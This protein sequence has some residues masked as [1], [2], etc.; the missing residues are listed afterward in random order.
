M[1]NT[2]HLYD[3]DDSAGPF[4]GLT[5]DFFQ[6]TSIR[7][8]SLVDASI[9]ADTT[10]DGAQSSDMPN[11]SC[12]MAAEAFERDLSPSDPIIHNDATIVSHIDSINL[13]LHCTD[14]LLDAGGG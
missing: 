2:W 13:N 11:E 6:D 1:A 5:E 7:V 12:V 9:E 14:I 10:H 4:M 3:F 8:P